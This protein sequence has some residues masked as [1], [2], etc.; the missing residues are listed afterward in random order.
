MDKSVELRQFDN[1]DY[2][3]DKRE[4]VKQWKQDK[5]EAK[6]PH[7]RALACLGEGTHTLEMLWTNGTAST[8][9][10]VVSAGSGSG[11]T[12][13][14]PTPDNS[15]TDTDGADNGNTGSAADATVSNELDDVPKTGDTTFP[16]E[17][18]VIM[19]VAG[20]GMLVTAMKRRRSIK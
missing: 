4:L 18:L 15:Q 2:R 10:T 1:V 12:P 5:Q 16:T 3:S 14:T 8:A 13:G 17:L 19:F 9:F 7:R 20:M 11:T 6:E